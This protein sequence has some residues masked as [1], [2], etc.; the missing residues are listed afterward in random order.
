M[1]WWSSVGE[2]QFVVCVGRNHNIL[3]DGNIVSDSKT[4]WVINARSELC[5]MRLCCA[6]KNT[7]SKYGSKAELEHPPP[8]CHLY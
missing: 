6:D 7:C 8:V 3:V 2:V 4:I 5:S 1:F